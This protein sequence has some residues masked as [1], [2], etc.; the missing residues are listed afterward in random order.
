NQSSE[1][2]RR[3]AGCSPSRQL[4]VAPSIP[5]NFTVSVGWPVSLQAQILDDCGTPSATSTV[6]VSFDNG[7]PP[8]VFN[9]LGNGRYAT[10]WTPARGS[11]SVGV[12]MRAR[13]A[14]L[15]STEW[16]LSGR[17]TREAA[18]PPVLLPGGVLNSASQRNAALIAPGEL[19]SLRGTNFTEGV[20]V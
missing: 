2:G 7:D 8:M 17:S 14:S 6:T 18:P 1:R 9:N 11:N 4:L 10:T 3:A 19:L 5:N 12:I 13:H 20:S 15:G 16:K